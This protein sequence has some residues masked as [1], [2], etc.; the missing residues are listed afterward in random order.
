MEIDGQEAV[1][2]EQRMEQYAR[3]S[4]DA[5]RNIQSALLLLLAIVILAAVIGLAAWVKG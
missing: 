2:H 1:T 4:A 5:L 3:Q